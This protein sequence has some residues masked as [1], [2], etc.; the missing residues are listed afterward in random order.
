MTTYA[1]I[2]YAIIEG[3]ERVMGNVAY[4]LANRVPG[5]SVEPGGVPSLNGDGP[6]M[7]EQLVAEYSTITGQLGVRMCYGAAKP[8][9]TSHPELQIPAFASL[10]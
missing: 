9:L 10:A 2:A 6:A 8:L 1:D 5:L 4:A 3:Q 7:I